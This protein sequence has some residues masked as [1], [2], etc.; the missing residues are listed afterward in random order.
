M[1]ELLFDTN[2][3]YTKSRSKWNYLPS[4]IVFCSMKENLRNWKAYLAFFCVCFFWGTTYVAIKIGVKNFPPILFVGIRQIVAGI[5]MCG[6]FIFIAHEPLPSLSQIKKILIGGFFFIIGA[7]LFMTM[8]SVYIPSGVAA[9]IATFLPFYILIINFI[10][11]KSEKLTMMSYIGLIIGGVGMIFIFYDSLVDLINPQ[12]AGGM[13]MMFSASV[14][15]AIGSVYMKNVAISTNGL[16]ASGIQMLFY[17]IIVL[18]IS[19]TIED[20]SNVHFAPKTIYALGYLIVFGSLVGYGSF[21]YAVSKI[22]PT[23]FS[24]Y[25][26]VNTVVAVI[27]GIV[28]LNEKVTTNTI[29]AVTCTIAGVYMVSRGYKKQK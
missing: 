1:T 8:G 22:E 7:N 23:L 12:Y 15:W 27:L 2:K 6:Y 21:I 5:I 29:I 10:I 28:L 19:F 9:L 16:F 11:G 20:I 3:N 18:A 26:Y 14:M 4:K 17:G 24:M 13:L 25:A